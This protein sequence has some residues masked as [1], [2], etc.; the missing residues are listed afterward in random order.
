[1]CLCD[2]SIDKRKVPRSYS[3]AEENASSLTELGMTM[4][5]AATVIDALPEF[6]LKSNQNSSSDL[7]GVWLASLRVPLHKM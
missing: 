6:F 7:K 1:M 3:D 4:D 2:C 5:L